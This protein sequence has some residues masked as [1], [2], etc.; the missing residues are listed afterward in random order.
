MLLPYLCSLL[1]WHHRNGLMGLFCARLEAAERR[2]GEKVSPMDSGM[3]CRKCKRVNIPVVNCTVRM[4]RMEEVI[5]VCKGCN[6]KH[7]HKIVPEY[8][9]VFIRTSE[10]IDAFLGE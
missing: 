3:L 8:K 7:S 1:L 4:T 2:A 10:D 9:S 6:S 5:I